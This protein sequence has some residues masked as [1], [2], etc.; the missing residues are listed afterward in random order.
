MTYSVYGVSLHSDWP[1]PYRRASRVGTL[2]TITLRRG[3]DARFAKALHAARLP[4]SSGSWIDH[5]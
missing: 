4:Q 1:L 5:R 3:S 2:A